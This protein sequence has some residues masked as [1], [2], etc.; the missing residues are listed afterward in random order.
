[1]TFATY[2][3]ADHLEIAL[4]ELETL[5]ETQGIVFSRKNTYFLINNLALHEVATESPVILVDKL[6]VV[7]RRV[8]LVHGIYEVMKV[9][10][11]PVGEWKEDTF[12]ERLDS[13]LQDI[14]FI[15]AVPEGLTF[16]VM[17]KRNGPISSVRL[18]KKEAKTIE[19]LASFHIV[20]HTGA[21]ANLEKP[22]IS[23]RLFI[24]ENHLVFTRQVH[25]SDRK[26][27]FGRYPSKRPFFHSSAMRPILIRAMVNLGKAGEKKDMV[28]MDPFCGTGGFLVE[29]LDIRD[30]LGLEMKLLG[31]DFNKWMVRGTKRNLQP[32]KA[33][34][35]SRANAMQLPLKPETV[36]LIVTDP[37]Y[38]INSSTGGI[39]AESVIN[40]SLTGMARVLKKGG[41][42]VFTITDKV[43]INYSRTGLKLLKRFKSRVHSSLTRILYV[44]EKSE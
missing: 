17:V 7:M 2:L 28:V 5:F 11:E 40:E 37:P 20:R 35:L 36:D 34:F 33:N 43:E 8:A 27:L 32:G 1:M 3:V 24:S 25:K 21:K 26:A 12:F 18:L 19:K 41:M 23:F 9:E 39:A 30:K 6:K 4:S 14:D 16:K 13:F 42:L 29:L 15:D 22:D 44:F 38:G 31:L 10:L